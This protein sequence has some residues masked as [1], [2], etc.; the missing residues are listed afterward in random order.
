MVAAHVLDER[1]PAG[2][3]TRTAWLVGGRA[4]ALF[5]VL[6]GVSLVLMSRRTNAAGLA[7]RAVLVAVLGLALGELDNGLAIILTYYGLLFLMGLPFLLLRA[8]TL[9]A[10]TLAWV[11]VGPVISQVVRPHL[12]PRGFASPDFGQ[13]EHPPQLLSELLFTG[14]YPCVPWL[15]YLLL[16]MA[17]GRADLRSRVL[18]LR[19]AGFGLAV[20]VLAYTVSRALTAQPWVLDRVVPDAAPYGDVS[21][22]DAFVDAI[23]SGM[24]GTTPTGGSW[25]WLLVVAPHSG[26]PFDLLE[27]GASA[28]FAIGA[29]LALLSVVGRVGART[30][31]V[32][33]GAGT[34]T[35]T[36]YS[37]HAVLRT[38]RFWPPEKP[39]SFGSHVVVLMSIGAVFVAL[40]WRGPL[41][42]LIGWL[43]G[44]TSAIRWPGRYPSRSAPPPPRSGRTPPRR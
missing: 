41:E 29:C 24:H 18:Q 36:L 2:G 6:A 25:A 8:R 16:G 38:E 9:V 31:A 35:L 14:Y 12:P 30:I 15:S 34:M 39:S 19:L 4:S 43:S 7:V 26:T 1:T 37:L 32:L 3:L 21:T 10:C 42:A 22:G 27:T 40:R 17:I 28:A 23:A 44:A 11:V 33:F 5:A 20:A 13:L